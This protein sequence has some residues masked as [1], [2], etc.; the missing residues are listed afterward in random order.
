MG[1]GNRKRRAVRRRGQ[2]FVNR[3]GLTSPHT[4]ASSRRGWLFW[5]AMAEIATMGVLR[6]RLGISLPLLTA[7]AAY[8]LTLAFGS[9]ALGDPDIYWHIVTGRWIIAHGG[10]PHQNLFSYTL[11]GVPWIAH[12]WLAEP[13]MAWL[14]DHFGWHGLVMMAAAGNAATMA[15]FSR[16]LLRFLEPH[17]VLL[18]ATLAWLVLLQHT[19]ARPHIIALPMMVA[20][21]GA[22]V[23]ARADGRAPPLV[24]ALLMVPWVNLHGSFLFGLLMAGLF[25]L[26]AAV[27]APTGAARWA[28]ARDWAL[29]VAAAAVASLVTP[30]GIISA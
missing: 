25:L 20:W 1:E 21:V 6:S 29:F 14:Y 15:I 12:E 23:T 30:N 16:V 28:A 9:G 5:V 22:L 27:L 3:V 18:V 4:S 26:E 7:L 8:A 13:L 19:L 17:H 2:D 24:L 10:V 11:P